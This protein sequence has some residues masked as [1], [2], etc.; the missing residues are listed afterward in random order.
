MDPP[1]FSPQKKTDTKSQIQGVVFFQ[2]S[3]QPDLSWSVK[4]RCHMMEQMRG[5]P[6]NNKETK[7]GGWED[8]FPFLA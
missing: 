3:H 6:E 5:I 2:N 1:F 7:K 8:D 4:L